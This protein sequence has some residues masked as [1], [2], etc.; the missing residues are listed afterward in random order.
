MSSLHLGD[1]VYTYPMSMFIDDHQCFVCGQEN[2]TG[3]RLRFRK[4]AGSAEADV[5]FPPYL[6]GWR[7]TVHGGALATVLDEVMVQAAMGSG[8]T[9]VT[10]E[11]TVV[12]KKPVATE[13]PYW[14]SGKVLETKGRILM[15]EGVL[16]DESGTVYARATSKLFRV[17]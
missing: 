4:G 17:E 16:M 7:A 2:P 12:Y 13:K 3:L 14:V 10:A 1:L 5:A 9:C 8:I 11:I 15:A 6:Q